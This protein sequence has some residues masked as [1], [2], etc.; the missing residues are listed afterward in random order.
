MTPDA[1]EALAQTLDAV[2]YAK[3][4]DVW[5]CLEEAYEL[6]RSETLNKLTDTL[7]TLR[8]KA[9]SEVQS[10]AYNGSYQGQVIAGEKIAIVDY[11]ERELGLC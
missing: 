1:T 3:L 7:S 2:G 9:D 10:A 8:S 6:G 5:I 4:S 11:I